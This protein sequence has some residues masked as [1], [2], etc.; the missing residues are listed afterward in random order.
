MHREASSRLLVGAGLITW[1]LAAVP[2]VSR[3]LTS[4][5]ARST[6]LIG[7]LAL[8]V[9][10]AA[11][12]LAT[13]DPSRARPPYLAA[14]SLAA[15]VFVAHA[16]GGFSGALLAVVAGQAPLVLSLPLA[17]GWVALQ[18]LALAAI[19]ARSNRAL[20]ALVGSG[21]YL[22]FQVFALGAAYLAKREADA[23]AETSRL[24]AELLATRELVAG[25][26]RAEE[27]L[28]IARE[29]HDAL[30]HG[31]TALSLQLEV[32]RNTEGDAVRAPV[33]RAHALAKDLMRD[34][35]AVVSAMRDD[36]EEPGKQVDLARALRLLVDGFTTPKMHLSVAEDLRVED[37]ARAH[38]LFRCAQEAITN[39]V[40]HADARNLWIE[41]RD[42]GEQ[43][44]LVARDD[45][46]G[47]R[48]VRAGNGLTGLDERLRALGGSCE[49]TS[50]EGRGLSLCARLPSGS[51]S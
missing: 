27:R 16:S 26:S 49:I 8:A 19:Y 18:T 42:D 50:T 15:L 47:A 40:R 33:G 13:T 11:Y 1:S 51:A 21:G 3:A 35:R 29:L 17:I 20:E 39:A 5:Q 45:G 48:E 28:R 2:F 37:A 31:L 10:G 12:V 22:G 14:Q 7:G 41:L 43:L 9:F 4:E 46:R 24:N 44:E 6:T 32:A 34:V 25:A 38:A 23:R 36:A 30:G